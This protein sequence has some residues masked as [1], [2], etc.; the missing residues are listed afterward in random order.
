MPV[1]RKHRL[2]HIHIPR[3]GGTAIEQFFHRLGDLVWGL[4]SWVGQEHYNGRWYELQHM[5]IGELK[6]FTGSEFDSNESFVV[7]RNP[8]ERIVSDYLWR[9]L[10]K[11]RYPN[12]PVLSFPSF[13]SFIHAIPADINSKWENLI[14]GA[15]QSQANLLIHVRPQYH[16]IEA[17]LVDH[18]LRFE[19]LDEEMARLMDPFGVETVSIR[20][21]SQRDVSTFFTPET[22]EVVNRIY[23]QD[24]NLFSWPRLMESPRG[25][26]V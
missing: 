12:A 14:H 8:Y 3:T 13:D 10:V 4:D 18:V 2:V 26:L 25:P 21:P 24:F 23:C 11:K 7:V 15:N 19:R 20:K 22:L 9:C 16:Y 5:T 6:S 17:E 1:Y